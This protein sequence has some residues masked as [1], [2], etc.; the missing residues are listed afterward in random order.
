MKVVYSPVNS[1]NKGTLIVFY[2][3]SIPTWVFFPRWRLE[4]GFKNLKLGPIF[5]IVGDILA[6]NISLLYKEHTFN[7]RYEIHKGRHQNFGEI[8]L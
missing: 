3:Q 5:F 7:L 4:K 6:I 8:H 1:G 2:G